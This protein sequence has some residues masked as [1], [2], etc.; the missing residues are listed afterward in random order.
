MNARA[1]KNLVGCLALFQTPGRAAT[2]MY[3][4]TNSRFENVQSSGWSKLTDSGS[5]NIGRG[6]I[7]NFSTDAPFRDR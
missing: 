4:R 2:D 3:S 6:R 7:A 1:L 5:S